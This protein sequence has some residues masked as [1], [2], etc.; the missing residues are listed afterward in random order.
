MQHRVSA[1]WTRVRSVPVPLADTPL[2]SLHVAN[3]VVD[4]RPSLESGRARMNK[5]NFRLRGRESDGRA[6]EISVWR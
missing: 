3:L 5:A 6:H 2:V 4:D 1:S